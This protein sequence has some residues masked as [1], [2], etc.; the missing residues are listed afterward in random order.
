M[1]EA[2]CD[3]CAL[4]FWV[5]NYDPFMWHGDLICLPCWITAVNS[6]LYPEREGLQAAQEDSP[7]QT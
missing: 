6:E 1:D 2:T 4:E 7:P 5:T 3:W